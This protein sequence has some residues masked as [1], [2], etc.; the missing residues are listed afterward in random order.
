MPPLLVRVLVGA[1]LALLAPPAAGAAI[2]FVR[3]TPSH[4]EWVY[5]ARDDGTHVRRLAQGSW[6]VLSPDARRVA[7]LRFSEL[8]NAGLYVYEQGAERR[9]SAVCTRAVTWSPDSRRLA[10]VTEDR[11]LLQVLDVETGRARTIGRVRPDPS[12]FGLGLSFSPDGRRLVYASSGPGTAH[13]LGAR[14]D[15]YVADAD[16]GPGRR[17]LRDGEAP[18][19]GSDL[20]VF[21]RRSREPDAPDGF[22]QLWLV[23]PDGSALRRLTDL[24][25][26]VPASVLLGLVP[27]AWSADGDRLVAV[28]RGENLGEGYGVDVASGRAWDLT[29]RE[30]EVTPVG[31]S[32]DGGRALVLTRGFDL[33]QVGDLLS[34]AFTGGRGRVVLRDVSMPHWAVPACCR[35]AGRALP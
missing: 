11:G 5:R 13:D 9:V 33:T 18:L 22:G 6:P 28:Y 7:S 29:P 2:V 23:R 26:L 4:V 24:P 31:L 20:I 17:I 34:V 30:L 1:V 12:L 25:V 19:W 32:P 27:L 3:A 14:Q 15:L 10:C 16:G 35:G 8:G 21:H